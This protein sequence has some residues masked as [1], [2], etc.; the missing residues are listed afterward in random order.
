[1][2]I[3]QTTGFGVAAGILEYWSSCWCVCVCAFSNVVDKELQLEANWQTGKRWL[4]NC[5]KSLLKM[6]VERA[7]CLPKLLPYLLLPKRND[8]SNMANSNMA[9]NNISYCYSCSCSCQSLK[10]IFAWFDT[11][12]TTKAKSY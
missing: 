7:Y 3:Q 4:S 12:A 8:D 5:Y 2:K 11:K 6:L 10:T 9:N 1:M